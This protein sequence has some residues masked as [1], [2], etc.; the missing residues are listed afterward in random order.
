MELLGVLLF[1]IVRECLI[2]PHNPDIYTRIYDPQPRKPIWRHV[3]A[4][5]NR[6]F[7][8]KV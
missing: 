1:F 8:R 3:A 4:R 5:L 7:Q 2:A 6:V